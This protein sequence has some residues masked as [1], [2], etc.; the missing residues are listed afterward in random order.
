MGLV[1]QW[2]RIRSELPEDWGEAKLDVSVTRP[3]S[4]PGRAL[5]GPAGPG[6]FG[7]DLRLSVHRAGGG[8]GPD[9]AAK[10]FRKLDEKDPRHARAR[11][12]RRAG[13][14]RPGGAG[15][16]RPALGRGA[17]DP[18]RTGATC[19]ASSSS[20]RATT[21]PRALLTAPLNPSRV[22]AAAHC[23]SARTFGYRASAADDPPL[24]RPP[25]RGGCGQVTSLARALRHAQRRHAG[26]RLARGKAVAVTGDPVAWL[27]IEPGWVVYDASGEGGQSEAGARGRGRRTSSTV[28]SSNAGLLGDDEKWSPTGSRRST[29]ATC[30]WPGQFCRGGRGKVVPMLRKLLGPASTAPSARSR[31]SSR[32][33]W[34][35]IWRVATGEKPPVKM[36]GDGAIE[37]GANKLEQLSDKAAAKGGLGGRSPTSSPTTRPSCAS[38]SPR[39]IA[40]RAKG[41]LPKDTE[42]GSTSVHEP[43]APGPSTT[44]RRPRRGRTRSSSPE[45]PSASGRCWQS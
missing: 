20:A 16:R 4:A 14:A 25:R 41:E 5:L 29:K 34:P 12:G 35:S 27:L 11:D 31:R 6:R 10:L 43:A 18:P 3:D 21:C 36:K 15:G 42:P 32:G 17:R 45:P 19:S 38:S 28:C 26:P 13:G 30:T 7:D 8:I 33:E 24:P 2:R 44:A 39:A 22:P 1:E 37:S 23:A 40:K 9:Q